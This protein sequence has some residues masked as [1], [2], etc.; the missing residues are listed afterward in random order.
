M[1]EFILL[2]IVVLAAA[3]GSLLFAVWFVFMVWG[4]LLPGLFG[5]PK[6]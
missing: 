2:L 1:I 5:K 3:V 4:V 6:E